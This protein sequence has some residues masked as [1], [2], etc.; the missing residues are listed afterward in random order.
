[1]RGSVSIG[2]WGAFVLAAV[3]TATAHAEVSFTVNGSGVSN[4]PGVN[5]VL[6]AR[7]VFT[8]TDG[9]DL[10]ITLSNTAEVGASR[11]G[12]V[13]TGLF[14]NLDQVSKL[15][16]TTATDHTLI[17]PTGS[18]FVPGGSYPDAAAK[19]W[20]RR[21]E[22]NNVLGSNG[23]NYDVGIG[24][25]GLG[26]G[27]QESFGNTSV[28]MTGGSNPLLNG[29]DYGLVSGFSGG[30]DGGN[31]KPLIQDS[32]EVILKGQ[33]GGLTSSA[34]ISGVW[35]QYGSSLSQS[36]IAGTPV[37]A[38]VPEPSFIQFGGLMAMGC[39]GSMFR[40]RRSRRAA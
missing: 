21:I 9:G 18:G 33:N 15:K 16:G 39:L 36:R 13:L 26:Q 25:S 17:V 6:K 24:A 14:F 30:Y 29:V 2:K 1:M 20:G 22:D 38:P 3:C 31:Q 7:A 23:A 10:K 27:S 35:F 8:V 28:F 37:A 11:H 19:H 32:V 4:E 40:A 34:A 12:D 5:S